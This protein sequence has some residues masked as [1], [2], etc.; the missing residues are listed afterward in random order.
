MLTTRFKLQDSE[1]TPDMSTPYEPANSTPTPIFHGES[2]L[3]GRP[4]LG[5]LTSSHPDPLQIFRLWQTCLDNVNPLAKVFHAPTVQKMIVEASSDL[6]NMIPSIEALMFAI[7]LSA[8]VSMTDEDCEKMMKESR[9]VQIT[10]FSNAAQQALINAEFLKSSDLM[11]LQAFTLF[12]VCLTSQFEFL[13]LESIQL[14]LLELSVVLTL[15]NPN[16]S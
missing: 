12:L 3:F 10:K 15:L 2:F 7:Y 8:V 13:A 11:V 14:F 1:N 16:N 4:N 5:S 6:S 9:S